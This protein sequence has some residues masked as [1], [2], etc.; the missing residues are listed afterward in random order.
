MDEARVARDIA[1][2]RVD[3]AGRH[4]ALLRSMQAGGGTVGGAAYELRS[5][6]D[7]V[8]SFAD[9]TPGAVVDVGARLLSV[10]NTDRL[11][12]EAKLFEPDAP[13][14]EHASGAA[15]TVAGIEHE[16]VIDEKSGR[17]VA[18][19]AVVDRV[20]R[21]VPI[22]FELENEGARLKPGMFAKVT[23]FT[24]QTLRALA[25]P[26]SA[27]I[28][29]DGKAAVFVMEGGESF[30]KRRVRLGVRS[31]GFVEVLA[32]VAQGERVVSRGAYEIKL[33]TASGAVPEHGHQH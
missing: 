8:I 28:D 17:L 24:G 14:V 30:F 12:L 22:V 20:T 32:G 10:V 27:L 4:Q 3:A 25:I 2:A 19:G 11:W 18:V 26:E 13:R 31:G 23:I 7:G 6:L 16:F 1:A 21:T 9:V 33:A 29:D 15:F 5:P